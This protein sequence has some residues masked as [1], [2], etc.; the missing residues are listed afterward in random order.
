MSQPSKIQISIIGAGIAGP[1]FA[2]QIL[3]HP[4]LRQHYTPIIYDKLPPPSDTS[5]VSSNT[6]G[7]SSYA[8]GAAVALTSNALFPLYELGLR[9]ALH[10][11]SCETTSI[12]IW[13][14]WHDSKELKN[15]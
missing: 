9:D 8:A 13:R 10:E 11:V 15:G 5:N 3:S 6:R 1:V 4:T 2:L 12:N 14:A 7:R